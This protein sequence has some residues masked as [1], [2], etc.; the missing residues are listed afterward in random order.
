MSSESGNAL[1]EIATTIKT[2]KHPDTLNQHLEN[3]KNAI[4]DLKIALEAWPVEDGDLLAVISA[5]TVASLLVEIVQT[6][7]KI[8]EAVYELAQMARF[9]MVEPT[10]SPEKQPHLLHRGTVKTVSDGESNHVVI[11][12]LETT[13]DSLQ[14]VNPQ[15]QKPKEEV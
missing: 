11:T 4:K 14:N 13:T 8:S 9:K 7:E 10:V 3:S 12:V 1:K 6:V 5:A 15:A 2:M